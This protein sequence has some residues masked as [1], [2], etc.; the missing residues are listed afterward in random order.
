MIDGND[1]QKIRAIFAKY[2]DTAEFKIA[3]LEQ[4]EF[5]IGNRKKIDSRHLSFANLSEFRNYLCNNTPLFVSHSTAYYEFPGATP[6][7]KKQRRGADLVFDLDIHAEGKYGAYEK[8]DDVKQDLQR[9]ANDF[10]KNDFGIKKEHILQVFSGNR[11]YHVHVRDP[12]YLDL[13]SEERRELVDYVMGQGL[14]YL[15]FFIESDT[16]PAR[17]L[18]PRPDEGGYRGRFA[19]QT[20]KALMEKPSEISRI[21]SNKEKRDF[22]ISGVN[23]GNWSRMSFK[24]DDLKKRLAHVAETL[25]VRCVDTDVGV[26]Q[27]LSKLIRVPNSIHGETG[28]IAKIID[29][30]EKFDPLKDAFIETKN[31]ETM[32]IKFTEDV[33]ELVLM[34]ET[35]EAF[36]KDD[37]KEFPMPLAIFYVLKGSANISDQKSGK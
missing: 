27:D 24:Y 8:L 10:I 17:L 19:R 16:K 29:D 23:E 18:G 30:I 1:L 28:W 36:K 2:Y 34:G 26:T 5:G 7:Q 9:L 37:E 12:A 13:G 20:I 31:K 15:D 25:P 6:I 33:P 11:G 32:K 3:A 21:F 22:F 14:N 35:K 4:R